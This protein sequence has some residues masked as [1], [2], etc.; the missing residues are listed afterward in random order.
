MPKPKKD[1]VIL[2]RLAPED[3]IHCRT[4]ALSR[5]QSMSSYAREALLAYEA[6]IAREKIDGLEGA[7]VQQFKVG[8]NVFKS[9]VN[10]ICGFLY[11]IAKYSLATFLFLDRMDPELM[12]EC[13]A[14]SVKMIGRNAH[15]DEEVVPEAMS[16]QIRGVGN[17]ISSEKVVPA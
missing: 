3:M 10:R 8:I 2:T 17:E 1:C 5:R 16:R 9:G 13:L 4:I 12:K 11:K 6:I 14:T 15:I 7:Y